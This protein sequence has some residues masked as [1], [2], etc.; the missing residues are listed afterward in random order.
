MMT[1]SEVAPPAF[2]DLH[3]AAFS[4][5]SARMYFSTRSVPT[6][7][8]RDMATRLSVDE[9]DFTVPGGVLNL[10]PYL[11]LAY[12]FHPESGSV[13]AVAVGVNVEVGAVAPARAM[14]GATHSAR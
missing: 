10:K 5:T 6:V 7:K 9:G 14:R 13:V 11:E 4:F 3:V 12:W 2:V 1:F 8:G